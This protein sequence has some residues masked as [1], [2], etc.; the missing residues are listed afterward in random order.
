MQDD[1]GVEMN[2][3]DL[4]PWKSNRGSEISVRQDNSKATVYDQF[5]QLFDEFF[6]N[7]WMTPWS[8]RLGE[9]F[10]EFTPRVNVTEREKEFEVT[11]ELPGMVESDIDITLSRD[12]ITVKGEKKQ[13][14]EDKGDNYY[15]MERSYGSFSRRIQLP[16][17]VIDKDNVEAEFKNG[18][19]TVTLP[20]LEDAQPISRRITVNAG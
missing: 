19:L 1:G 9:Q 16:T 5:N 14:I 4:V 11:A 18:V 8:D 15:R 10:N 7:N 13:E 20:K 2:I 3:S 12:S 17:D 6:E